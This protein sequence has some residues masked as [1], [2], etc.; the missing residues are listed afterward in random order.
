MVGGLVFSCT[1]LFMP[2]SCRRSFD[3]VGRYGLAC[4]LILTNISFGR[5]KKRVVCS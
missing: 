2:V 1:R 5:V 3:F 4:L